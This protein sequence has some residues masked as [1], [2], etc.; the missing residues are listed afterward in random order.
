M[1]WQDFQV[2]YYDCGTALPGIESVRTF[3]FRSL[4]NTE[5]MTPA[6]AAPTM[7]ATQKSHNCESAQPRTNN[8]GPMLRAGFTEV[9]VTGMLIK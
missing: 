5:C 1:F 7:G 6:R 2:V 3:S 4:A 9:F 8:A